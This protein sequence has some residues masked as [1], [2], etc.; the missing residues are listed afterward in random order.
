MKL[1]CCHGLLSTQPNFKH[2]FSHSYRLS[3]CTLKVG[4]TIPSP[5]WLGHEKWTLQWWVWAGWW[6]C[7]TS[8]TLVKCLWC[9]TGDELNSHSQKSLQYIPKIPMFCLARDWTR[10]IT[11]FELVSEQGVGKMIQAL[12][13]R[14]ALSVINDLVD[15]F[16]ALRNLRRNSNENIKSFEIRSKQRFV[17]R[18]P[19]LTILFL[20]NL[21]RLLSIFLVWK[22]M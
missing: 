5:V 15:E 7:R 8:L 17:T 18:N 20:M 10:S 14:H 13:K 2:S 1:F 6:S 12:N 3:D 19:M 4:S 11:P 16:N 22:L 21:F 9:F